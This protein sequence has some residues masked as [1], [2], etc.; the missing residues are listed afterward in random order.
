MKSVSFG[1][2]ADILTLLS[3]Q[4]IDCKHNKLQTDNEKVLICV[5]P[6]LRANFHYT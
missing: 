3:P 2:V 4:C 1:F 6:I 5:K